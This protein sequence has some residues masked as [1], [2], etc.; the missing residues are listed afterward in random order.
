[1]ASGTPRYTSYGAEDRS[2]VTELPDVPEKGTVILK[3]I[4]Y[5]EK[6]PKQALV[7]GKTVINVFGEKFSTPGSKYY[8]HNSKF[9]S[10]WLGRGSSAYVERIDAA[11]SNNPANM[12]IYVD[13]L[14]DVPTPNYVRDSYGNY[15]GDGLGGYKVD[16]TTPTILTTKI[17]FLKVFKNGKD[18]LP[19]FGLLKPMVGTMS[20][21]GKDTN[22][23][24]IEIKSTAYPIL[25]WAAKYRGEYY[26]NIGLGF[27]SYSQYDI[28]IDTVKKMKSMLYGFKLFQRSDASTT[29]KITKTL[30]NMN[31]LDVTLKSN[32]RNP[33]TEAIISLDSTF[34][35]SYYNEKKAP[36]R[37]QDTTNIFVYNEYL[38]DILKYIADNEKAYMSDTPVTWDDGMDAANMDWFDYNSSSLDGDEYL[39]N[40]FTCTSTKGAPYYTVSFDDTVPAA[41]PAN[42]SIV[43][44][45]SNT[46]VFLDGGSD[47]DMS[48]EDL[49]SKTSEI[50]KEYS[51]ETSLRTNNIKYP[52]MFWVDSGYPLEVKK[53]SF[54]FITVRPET[55]LLNS[56]EIYSD[57]KIRRHNA[58]NSVGVARALSLRAMLAPESVYFNTDCMRS[59]LV[60]GSFDTESEI[61]FTASTFEI[62]DYI[63]EMMGGTKWKRD[64]IFDMT[65]YGRH[66]HNYYP[67]TVSEPAKN[68][69]W[70]L[71]M[72]MPEITNRGVP[73]YIGLCTMYPNSTSVANNIFTM[74]A[75]CNCERLAKDSYLD[76]GGNVTA[77]N[78]EFIKLATDN[79]TKKHKDLFANMFKVN[80]NVT[81]LGRDLINGN[82]YTV[83]SHLYG[84]VAKTGCYH[85]TKVYRQ[86]AIQG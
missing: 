67:D 51:D 47:G 73:K 64:K 10:Q 81:I 53:D 36:V 18:E 48:L 22:G 28:N 55:A 75:L 1:M 11:N 40:L 15:V 69:L 5:A 44:F 59:A 45:T 41:M 2:S 83:E 60:Y 61:E 52:G 13:V 19:N 43:K 32:T 56:S 85:S 58:A 65:C 33:D 39:I 6:G 20:M 38:G 82:T 63:S 8:F 54:H 23:D 9:L 4:I 21:T 17:K 84:N 46:P 34:V 80:I 27:D 14:K 76:V 77:T 50:L 7:N 3:S 68:T 78:A 79:L 42:T 86:D 16:A 70:D 26:N 72:I 57:L 30:L 24:D 31:F 35:N 74:L 71:G 12:Q 49:H 25:E 29:A 66:G 62:M 37:F